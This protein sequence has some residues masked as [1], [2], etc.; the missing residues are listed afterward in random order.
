MKK[1]TIAIAAFSLFVT[2]SCKKSSDGNK[3]VIVKE[4][5]EE[6]ISNENGKTDSSYTA[7]KTVE[8]G[9]AKS[10]EITER[11]VAEDGSS[12]LVT[13]KNSDTEHTISIRSNNKTIVAEQKASDGKAHIYHNQDIEIKSENDKVTITQGNNVI[14]LKKARGQ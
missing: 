7:E 2:F 4:N 1:F 5:V 3:S 9:N 8:N 6:K 12:A 14:E 11:Y 13:F 10:Q